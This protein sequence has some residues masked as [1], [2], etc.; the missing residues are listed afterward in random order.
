MWAHTPTG[1]S[2][3]THSGRKLT[4]SAEQLGGEHAVGDD[5]LVAVEV[6][7]EEVERGEA[8]DQPGLDAVP[9]G[10]AMTRGMTSKG[11]ARSMLAP[12]S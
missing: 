10:G 9:L 3:P 2:T 12:S 6:V 7:D 4:E 8:L 5:L 1:G 11:Q